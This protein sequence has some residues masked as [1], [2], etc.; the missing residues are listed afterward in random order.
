MPQ[1]A[2]RFRMRAADCRQLATKVA[3]A[4]D[5]DLLNDIAEELDAEADRIEAEPQDKS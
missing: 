4:R 5:R 2:M 3:E 1:D